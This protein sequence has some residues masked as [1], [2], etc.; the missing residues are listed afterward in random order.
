MWI[1]RAERV[2]G[3]LRRAG[4]GGRVMDK[5]LNYYRRRRSEEQAAEH[6]AIHPAVRAVHHALAREYEERITDLEA[7]EPSRGLHIVSAT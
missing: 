1:S 4:H 6:S 2:A 7:S 3:G 5:D